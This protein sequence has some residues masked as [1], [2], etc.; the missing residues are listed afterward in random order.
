MLSGHG[1]GTG[2]KKSCR[3]SYSGSLS[4]WWGLEGEAADNFEK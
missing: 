4:S 2:S 1:R 3:E